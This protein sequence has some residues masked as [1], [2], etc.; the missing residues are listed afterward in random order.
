MTV[1]SVLE[2]KAHKLMNTH[3][4]IKLFYIHTKATVPQMEGHSVP[5][6]TYFVK[7]RI[8]PTMQ[9]VYSDPIL[10]YGEHSS[11]TWPDPCRCQWGW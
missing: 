10:S 5:V 7:Q 3:D 1:E 8:K 2:K 4:I 9:C 6:I 11:S